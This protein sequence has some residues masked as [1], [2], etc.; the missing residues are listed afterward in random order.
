MPLFR[1][2]FNYDASGENII[3]KVMIK[4]VTHGRAEW[5]YIGGKESTTYSKV[6]CRQWSKII[7]RLYTQCFIMQSVFFPKINIGIYI[8]EY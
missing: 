1:R 5:A 3:Q 8:L 4:I 7:E 6:L 2:L